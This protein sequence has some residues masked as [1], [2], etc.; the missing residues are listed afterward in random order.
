MRY[1]GGVDDDDVGDGRCRAVAAGEGVK[2]DFERLRKLVCVEFARGKEPEG[3]GRSGL[4]GRA[5]LLVPAQGE[6]DEQ[7]GAVADVDPQLAA[8]GAMVR[9]AAG[10]SE[11]AVVSGGHDAF[12][13]KERVRGFAEGDARTPHGLRGF[14]IVAEQRREA[15]IVGVEDA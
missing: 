8:L 12:A 13:A 7:R 6:E 1:A 11:V 2:R 4:V 3:E 14:E 9:Y 15:S 10:H 5:R